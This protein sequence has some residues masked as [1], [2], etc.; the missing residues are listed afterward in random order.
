MDHTQCF[1]FQIV[2]L[3]CTIMKQAQDMTN[4]TKKD[5]M[6]LTRVYST[7]QCNTIKSED[8][9]TQMISRTFQDLKFEEKFPRILRTYQEAWERRKTVKNKKDRLKK[10]LQIPMHGL[11][12]A[13]LQSTLQMKIITAAM[14]LSIH[15]RDL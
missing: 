15:Q 10:I 11:N 4:F 14:G 6:A 3:R 8:A 13:N 2:V 9:A 12:V 7:I 5:I 1:L